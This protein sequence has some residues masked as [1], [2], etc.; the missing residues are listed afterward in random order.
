MTD[1]SSLSVP[2]PNRPNGL[3]FAV[4]GV[5]SAAALAFLTWLLVLRSPTPGGADLAFMPAV[6][7]ALNAT[8]ATC[9]VVAFRAIK[10]GRIERHRLFMTIAF[11]ASAL[12]LIG[13]VV[14]HYAHGDTRYPAEAPLR[15]PYLALLASH[16]L[17]SLPVVPLVLTSFWFALRGDFAKHKRVTRFTLPIWL[18]V[19]VTGVLVFVMLRA[20]G[21]S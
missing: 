9:L 1:P 11:V 13:Y 4:N 21:A 18:Y 16:V 2:R 17:L 8:S 5:V 10:A 7:A 15:I 12:F 19:S 14:Y 20:A 3:F 6:N